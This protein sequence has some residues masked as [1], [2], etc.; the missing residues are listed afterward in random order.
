[1]GELIAEVIL[2]AGPAGG[3]VSPEAVFADVVEGVGFTGLSGISIVA[4]VARVWG[5]AHVSGILFVVGDDPGFAGESGLGDPLESALVSV[6]P[7]VLEGSTGERGIGA[8]QLG[9]NLVLS[10]GEGVDDNG[11]GVRVEMFE[12]GGHGLLL[13]GGLGVFL[14]QIPIEGEQ[15]TKAR[16]E[17]AAVEFAFGAEITLIERGGNVSE[18]RF[19]IAAVIVV[20]LLLHFE[21]SIKAAGLGVI[22]NDLPLI[23][24]GAVVMERVVAA[25]ER[26]DIIAVAAGIV[27]QKGKGIAAFAGDVIESADEAFAFAIFPG[28]IGR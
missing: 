24:F 18:F 22:E 2:D 27:G 20:F 28:G 23:E 4:S 25:D 5:C 1:M 12:V 11:V 16:D 14:A 6:T 10:L 3:E 8:E 19:M 15:I 21:V 7:T 17:F 26:P 9:I 13:G